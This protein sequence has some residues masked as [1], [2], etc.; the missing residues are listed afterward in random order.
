LTSLASDPGFDESVARLSAELGRDPHA[1]RA[2]VLSHAGELASKHGRIASALWRRL[3]RRLLAAYRLRPDSEALARLHALAADHTLIWLPSHRSYLDTWALP[4]V[5]DDAGFPPYFVLGGINLDFWPFGDLARRTGLVFIRRNIKKDPVYRFALRRHLMHL[6]RA[7]A[8]FGW[9][10]EG[11]RTRTGKL[12]P[13]RYGLLRYV[14]DV[15]L[16]ESIG[17]RIL[18]VPVSIVYDQ[19]PEVGAMTAEARGEVKQPE[20]L[21]WLVRFARQQGRGSG[22]VHITFAEPI[23]LADH[24]RQLASEDGGRGHEVER[25]ALEVCHRINAV[26]PVLPTALATIALLAADRGLTLEEVAD[27]VSPIAA[28]AQRR[29]ALGD[30]RLLED[31]LTI[32]SALNE[33]VR[34]EAVVAFDGGPERIWAIGP[35]QHLTAAFYRNSALHLLVPRAIAELC[36]EG[37][38]DL[39]PAERD[40]VGGRLALEFRDLLKFEFFFPRKRD[41]LA[42]L[43]VEVDELDAQPDVPALAPLVLRP[44][45]EAYLVVATCLAE[46]DQELAT[47]EDRLLAACLGLASQWHLQRRLSSAESISLELFRVARRLAE[48]RGLLGAGDEAILGRQALRSEVTHALGLIDAVASRSPSAATQLTETPLSR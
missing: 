46:G 23:R 4:Q 13:P 42:Q 19:L 17:D 37:A 32:E 48:H 10:I 35:A 28:F 29:G 31:P 25:V 11:G 14:S 3:G 39:G 27:A 18:L 33:L 44:F 40:P 2:E 24:L 8:D 36:R 12:R 30:H 7:G 45:L 21:R 41:F 43:Q 20:D 38:R 5:L 22:D 26:T 47:D 1:V 9:S 6:V 34:A 16:D 15:A